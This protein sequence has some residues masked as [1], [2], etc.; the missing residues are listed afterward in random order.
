M[1]VTATTA[2]EIVAALTTTQANGIAAWANYALGING[3]VEAN[4]PFAAPVQNGDSTMLTFKLGGVKPVAGTGATVTYGVAEVNSPSDT[5]EPAQYVGVGESVELK[6]PNTVKYY[7]I[8][9]KID[10]TQ[11]NN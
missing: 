9:T 10:Q 6:V 8:K 2:S 5:A 7:R 4:K 1:G 11:T 3:T